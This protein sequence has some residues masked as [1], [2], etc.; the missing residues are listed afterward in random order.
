MAATASP[1]G[2]RLPTQHKQLHAEDFKV[3][4]IDLMSITYRSTTKSANVKSN[5]KKC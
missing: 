1:T 2:L 5:S 4:T 3:K